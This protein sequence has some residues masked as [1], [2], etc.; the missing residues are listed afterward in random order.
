MDIRLG[1][2]EVDRLNIISDVN[3]RKL[4]QLETS[5]QLGITTRQVRRLALRVRNEGIAGIMS[6]HRGRG[7]HAFSLEFKERVLNAV[8]ERY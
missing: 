4:T 8:K 7:N 6:R 5:K 3:S 1:E 2:A